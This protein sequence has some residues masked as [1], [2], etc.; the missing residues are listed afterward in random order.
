[1]SWWRPV[2]RIERRIDT[3]SIEAGKGLF[4]DR[5]FVNFAEELE[6]ATAQ[7]VMYEEA[8]REERAD[9]SEFESIALRFRGLVVHAQELGLP[10]VPPYFRKALE[11]WHRHYDK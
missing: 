5:P 9:R 3:T 2:R 10:V 11:K 6:D 1:M 7:L 4:E 8:L